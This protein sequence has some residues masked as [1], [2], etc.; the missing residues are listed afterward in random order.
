MQNKITLH[1]SP[2]AAYQD[3]GFLQQVKTYAQRAMYIDKSFYRYRM[4][5]VGSSTCSLNGMLFYMNEFMW[6]NNDLGLLVDLSDIQETYYF[7]T[8]S[9]A[10]YYN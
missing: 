9:V 2:K 1:E 8:M 7:Y 3:M 6:I 5:R 4:G 10:F